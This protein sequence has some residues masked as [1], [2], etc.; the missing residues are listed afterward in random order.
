MDNPP[1]AMLDDERQENG[2]KEQVIGL[3]KIA[4]P[5]RRGVISQKGGPTLAMRLG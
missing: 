3:D 5:N 4:R 1:G 2:P